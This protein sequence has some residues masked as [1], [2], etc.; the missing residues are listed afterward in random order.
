MHY[1]TGFYVTIGW[2]LLF[3]HDYNLYML[4]FWIFTKDHDYYLG[5][6]L[7]LQEERFNIVTFKYAYSLIQKNGGYVVDRCYMND[8]V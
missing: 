7:W 6:N 8:C 3:V 5:R 4:I 1:V 2:L